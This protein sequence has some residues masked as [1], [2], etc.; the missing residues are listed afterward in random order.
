MPVPSA[1]EALSGTHVFERFEIITAHCEVPEDVLRGG[2][3]SNVRNR[4]TVKISR[5]G[6]QMP[7]N[8]PQKVIQD[9]PR[10]NQESIQQILREDLEDRMV[11]TKSVPHSLTVGLIFL[12]TVKRFMANHGDTN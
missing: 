12:L 3:S 11:F 2:Q 10:I 1:S 9:L 8:N 6:G 4:E 7:S 5:N